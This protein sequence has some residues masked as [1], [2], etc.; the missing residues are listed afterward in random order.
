[1][2]ELAEVIREAFD[3]LGREAPDEVALG[4]SDRVG[5]EISGEDLDGWAGSMDAEAVA[6]LL[7]RPP[8]HVLRTLDATHDELVELARRFM[9]LAGDELLQHADWYMAVFDANVPHPAGSSLAFHPPEG[10]DDPTP[11]MLVRWATS[12]RAIQSRLGSHRG[13]S[14]G[15]DHSPGRTGQ[16]GRGPSTRERRGGGNHTTASRSRIALT[17]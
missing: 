7:V 12:Y 14:A 6:S 17:P 5:I 11:E 1:L 4:V 2:E 15:N 13:R 10:A 9:G 8:R 3:R 16:S